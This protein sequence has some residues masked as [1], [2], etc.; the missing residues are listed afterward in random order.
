MSFEYF[1][2]TQKKILIHQAKVRGN[3]HCAIL[4]LGGQRQTKLLPA[5]N[6]QA[7]ICHFKVKTHIAYNLLVHPIFERSFRRFATHC[8]D[9]I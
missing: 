8:D 5:S 1:N 3:V 2:V 9:A 7:N 4:A 6:F